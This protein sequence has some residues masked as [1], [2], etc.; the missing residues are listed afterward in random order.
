MSG[1]DCKCLSCAM[2]Q[3]LAERFP[4]GKGVDE[5]TEILVALTNLSGRYLA[6]TDNTTTEGFV[7]AVLDRRETYQ[8]LDAR[9]P[10]AAVH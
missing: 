10:G 4:A 6:Y 1:K 2:V 5:I 9:R 8:N 3:L 7:E